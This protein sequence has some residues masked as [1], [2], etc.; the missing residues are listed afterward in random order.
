MCVIWFFLFVIL[1]WYVFLR[2]NWICRTSAWTWR[3]CKQ[4][5][6]YLEGWIKI[7]LSSQAALFK[8]AICSLLD[9]TMDIITMLGQKWRTSTPNPWDKRFIY[10]YHFYTSKYHL[11]TLSLLCL[12]FGF[13]GF[14]GYGDHKIITSCIIIII[15]MYYWSKGVWVLSTWKRFERVWVLC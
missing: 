14:W 8:T 3:R 2:Y 12:G 4:L 10:T 6:C 15:I 11:L 1:W 5:E 9:W 7:S 13:A